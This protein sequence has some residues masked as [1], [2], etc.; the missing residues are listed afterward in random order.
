MGGGGGSGFSFEL[1]PAGSTF[2]SQRPAVESRGYCAVILCIDG[3][4]GIALAVDDFNV[5]S[6]SRRGKLGCSRR[7]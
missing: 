3:K 7:D 5:T 2:S 6:E 1:R 4:V